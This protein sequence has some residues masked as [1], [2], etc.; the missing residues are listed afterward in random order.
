MFVQT[1][2]AVGVAT[3]LE[4]EETGT[5]GCHSGEDTDRARLLG[6]T[7]VSRCCV[8]PK[9]LTFGLCRLTHNLRKPKRSR[10]NRRP[11]LSKES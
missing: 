1:A 7:L 10:S 3:V 11:F 9:E 4:G 5:D 6:R 8:A 2:F